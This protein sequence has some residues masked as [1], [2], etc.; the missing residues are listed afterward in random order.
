MDSGLLAFLMG[1]G[2]GT[3]NGWLLA[4]IFYRP[5]RKPPSLSEEDIKRTSLA[6]ERAHK[7]IREQNNEIEKLLEERQ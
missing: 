3:L 5:A 1:V 2:L 4:V 7:L 6:V